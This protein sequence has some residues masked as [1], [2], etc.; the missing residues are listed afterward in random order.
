MKADP[1]SSEGTSTTHDVS[2]PSAF[3]DRPVVSE[4]RPARADERRSLTEQR[5]VVGNIS[6]DAAPVPAQ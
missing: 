6:G 2:M 4:I 1:V 5:E 3:K